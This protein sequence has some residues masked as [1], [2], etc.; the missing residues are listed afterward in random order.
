MGRLSGKVAL[1]TG[2][3]SGLGKADCERFV[4]EGAEVYISDIDG[5]RAR[6]LAEALGPAASALQHDV[7]SEA[8]WQAAYATIAER[9][10]RM[11]VLVNNAGIVLVADPEE[12]TLDQYERVMRVMATSVFIG[13]KLGI[14][15]LRKSAGASIINMSSVASHLGYPPFFAYSAAKGAV[16]SMSKAL[17]VHCQDK[18]Y[19]IRVN[20]LH[21]SS[22]E[23][24]MVQTAEGRAG[25]EQA[26]PAGVLPAGATGA[27]ADVAN[28]VLFLASDESRFIT[29]AEFIIDNGLTIRP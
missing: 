20:T 9:H 23:T 21:P 7:S 22:I 2:A 3:A 29:G 28:L 27:P 24:P 26:I 16:R 19:P 8:D 1:V 25:Q 4:A 6:A 15:L 12:T 10:G 17:A 5:E 11:D 18:G 14:P 13:C